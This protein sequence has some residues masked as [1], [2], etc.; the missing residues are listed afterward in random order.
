MTPRRRAPAG[1]PR[2]MGI[3]PCD[4][5]IIAQLQQNGRAPYTSVANAVGLSQAAVRQRVRRLRQAGQL[6]I[7]AVAGPS[8]VGAGHRAVIRICCSGDTSSAADGLAEM[9]ELCWIV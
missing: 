3:D 8:N 5:A 6:R 4:R 1:K 2:G 9:A 7:T